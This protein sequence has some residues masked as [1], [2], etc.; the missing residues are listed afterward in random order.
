MPDVGDEAASD[1]FERQEAIDH[2]AAER[3]VA[4]LERQAIQ[5]LLLLV[6]LVR[7]VIELTLHGREGDGGCVG[8]LA[9]SWC[10]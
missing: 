1:L 8:Q 5:A 7:E 9:I 10:M 4:H 6:T 3:A 2:H